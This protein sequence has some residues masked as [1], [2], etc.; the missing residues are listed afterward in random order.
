M[1]INGFVDFAI[2]GTPYIPPIPFTPQ[3]QAETYNHADKRTNRLYDKVWKGVPMD[4][5]PIPTSF[6]G[7][8]TKPDISTLI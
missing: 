3:Y 6:H 1:A 2:A 7:F 8:A 4:V 5:N